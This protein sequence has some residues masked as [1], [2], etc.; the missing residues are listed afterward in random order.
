MKDKAFVDKLT[1]LCEEILLIGNFILS[2]KKKEKDLEKPF[3]ELASILEKRFNIKYEVVNEGLLATMPSF[4]SDNSAVDNNDIKE[5]LQHFPVADLIDL[6]SS[7]D[8]VMKEDAGFYID[9]KNKEIIY[10]GKNKF[11]AILYIGVTNLVKIGL[12]GNELA[13]AI[14]HEIGHDFEYLRYKIYFARKA[15]HLID[16]IRTAMK[17]DNPLDN[18]VDVVVKETDSKVDINE[19]SL[20]DKITILIEAPSNLYKFSQETYFKR[21]N[22]SD[23]AVT[24]KEF[25]TV[26]DRFVSNFNL[27]HYLASGLNKIN[28]VFNTNK[29]SYQM[30]VG[31]VIYVGL[32]EIL[33]EDVQDPVTAGFIAG[34]STILFYIFIYQPL[35][36]TVFGK[37]DNKTKQTIAILIETFARLVL[38]L[39]YLIM[40]GMLTEMIIT[41]ELIM[42]VMGGIVGL[43]NNYYANYRES[44]TIPMSNYENMDERIDSVKRNLISKLK[45]VKD[46]KIKRDILK[47]IDFVNEQLKEVKKITN[48]INTNDVIPA[49]VPV[50]NIFKD[51]NSINPIYV[52][53]NIISKHINN[54]LYVSAA[55]LELNGES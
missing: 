10:K 35:F 46:P 6:L 4:G 26:A 17:T 25:E 52:L 55:K 51:P 22:M 42:T 37:L 9:D 41:P 47:Q 24:N 36:N 45:N 31:P 7:N 53:N 12:T 18:I 2:R 1:D 38:I 44:D 54:D 28:I 20:K 14:L 3:K 8:K 23:K 11:T 50:I 32:F 49:L 34:Y 33:M 19:L 30:L 5:Y 43:I 16:E 48:K 13:A 15:E 29:K 40:I 21:L 27:E 39:N